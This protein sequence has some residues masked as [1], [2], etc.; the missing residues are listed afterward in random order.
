MGTN[1]IPVINYELR[2]TN[3]ELQS[4]KYVMENKYQEK[5]LLNKYYGALEEIGNFYQNGK[6]SLSEIREIAHRY[7]LP[8]N[9]YY[10]AIVKGW[11][12][13]ISNSIYLVKFKQFTVRNARQ[14]MEDNQHRIITYKEIKEFIIRISHLSNIVIADK[15]LQHFPNYFN[16]KNDAV[17]EVNDILKNNIPEEAKV[18]KFIQENL[19]LPPFKIYKKVEKKFNSHFSSTE[20]IRTS[21]N[22]YLSDLGKMTIVQQVD[23]FINKN[24][25]LPTHTLYNKVEKEF[26]G[27]FKTRD[28]IKTSVN[29]KLRRL[30]TNTKREEVKNFIME[31]IY[32]PIDEIASSVIKE[33]PNY[34]ASLQSCKA[35]IRRWKVE[36]DKIHPSPP[37]PPKDRIIDT[38]K[39]PTPPKQTPPIVFE[40]KTTTPKE[41]VKIKFTKLQLAIAL[42]IMINIITILTMIIILGN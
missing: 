17:S 33:F 35:S 11:L 9:F 5:K 2:I 26:P 28:S 31:Q 37:Q 13:I 4:K 41:P 20:S 7:E 30:R 8:A 25:H 32:L 21:V 40:E 16:Q 1:D 34:Y 38:D 27:Y 12:E 29:R 23:N 24:S 42:V 6:I 18:R 15:V 10:P 19:H 36:Y 14:L 3:Y 39:P 22:Y